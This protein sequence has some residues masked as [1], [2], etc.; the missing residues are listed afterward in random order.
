MYQ[1]S[2]NLIKEKLLIQA[3]STTVKKLRKEKLKSQRMLADEYEIQ[4]S[5]LSR[6]E[7][8]AN[9]P[10]F[11]SVWKVAEA[12]GVKPSDFVMLIEKELPENFLLTDE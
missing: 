12:L 10:M 1:N 11:I 9:S 4:K 3:I 8:A 6:M 2:K 7:S 5:L